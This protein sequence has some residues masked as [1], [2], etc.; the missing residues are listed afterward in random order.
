MKFN[1]QMVE[2]SLCGFNFA[3]Y[4]HS[5]PS[6]PY[7]V[8]TITKYYSPR[9]T[10]FRREMLATAAQYDKK[11][12]SKINVHRREVMCDLLWW[13]FFFKKKNKINDFIFH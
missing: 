8:Y 3:S 2:F 9:E 10:Y 11:M 5:L 4:E 13:V 6:R 1:N 12:F 7:I